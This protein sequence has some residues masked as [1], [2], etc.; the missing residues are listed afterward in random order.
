MGWRK[1]QAAVQSGKLD[2]SPDDGIGSAIG[3]GLSSF[4]DDW[5]KQ[6]K[7]QRQKKLD[8]DKEAAEE[9]K[10]L[11]E[12]QKTQEAKDKKMAQD[13]KNIVTG[14]GY[15]PSNTNFFQTVY[16]ELQT[17]D[18]DV[19]GTRKY[20][21]DLQTAGRLEVAGPAMDFPYNNTGDK[22]RGGVDGGKDTV[23]DLVSKQTDEAFSQDKNTGVRA[24]LSNTESSGDITAESTD[25]QGRVH[26]GEF[27]FGDARLKD[28]NKVH[29]TNYVA[30][31]MKSMSSQEQN[32]IADWH[33]NNI[34]QFIKSSG[35]DRFIG[36]TING[37]VLT[38][39]SLV[40]IAHLGG[41]GGL[42]SYLLSDGKD[43]PADDNGTRLSDYAETHKGGG[44]I[45]ELTE[46]S[47]DRDQSMMSIKPASPETDEDN[48]P[49]SFEGMSVQILQNSDDYKN[50]TPEQQA[51]MVA[52]A[53]EALAK[54]Q[55]GDTTFTSGKLAK[56]LQEARTAKRA[57]ETI[58]E[59]QRS[60]DQQTR[61]EAA[62]DYINVQYPIDAAVLKE[63]SE[64]TSSPENNFEF[65]AVIDGMITPGTVVDGKFVP[66]V[67]P[68]KSYSRAD[69]DE[70][71]NPVEGYTSILTN[72][73]Y[74]A[75]N[76]QLSQASQPLEKARKARTDASEVVGEAFA[77]SELANKNKQLLTFSGGLGLSL[78]QA[79]A[80][81]MTA[82]FSK[83]EEAF[84]GGSSEADA[85]RLLA[86]AFEGE[87]ENIAV[88]REFSAAMTRFIF[89]A[90]KALGQSGNGFSNADYTNIRKSMLSSN[91]LPDFIN[92][93]KRFSKERLNAADV[94]A[95]QWLKSPN[96]KGI[97]QIDGGK[98]RLGNEGQTSQEYYAEMMED[99]PD[100]PDHYAWVQST[101]ETET[102]PGNENVPNVKN[103]L[104]QLRDNGGGEFSITSEN[105]DA[106]K[107]MFPGYFEQHQITQP[108]GTMTIPGNN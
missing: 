98:D 37:T 26:G 24:S 89:A 43:N 57:I 28:Y 51:E 7:E 62:N 27:Q 78:L 46:A 50:A 10:K 19:V 71:G 60:L 73:Q 63:I 53:K 35:L 52:R 29:G 92:N 30:T 32:K 70:N 11:R 80:D 91:S 47:L 36:Q 40:A 74:K 9:R 5:D 69:V 34:G 64:D 100:G 96:Y 72:E 45:G 41:Q 4:A 21:D 87:Q 101:N 58:P 90:G 20:F 105:F 38:E 81:E 95:R 42:R 85:V 12:A 75:L 8:D 18:G 14:M 84:N 88:Y 99:F 67:D 44:G 16:A 68:T 76:Q 6:I 3:R 13:A 31:D 107:Q 17:Q 2:F 15:D 77:L 108:G 93:M 49:T 66:V 104:K 48:V 61:L 97:V 25:D 82:L 54:K 102:E 56:L 103:A 39:A 33:F 59:E 86:S 65:Y 106:L 79:G 94:E 83:I 23:D 1:T 55:S 22:S